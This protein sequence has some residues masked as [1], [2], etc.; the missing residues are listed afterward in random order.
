MDKKGDV[1]IDELA[2]VLIAILVLVVIVMVI[3]LLRDK[4]LILF[5]RFKNLLG[6]GV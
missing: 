1:E 5:E 3:W 6:F 2:K 4:M